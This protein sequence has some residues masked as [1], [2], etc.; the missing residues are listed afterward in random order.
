MR[1]GDKKPIYLFIYAILVVSFKVMYLQTQKIWMKDS[2][3][4]SK[5]E[6][7]TAAADFLIHFNWV[8]LFTEEELKQGQQPS[9][10]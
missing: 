4:G 2:Y 10:R 7:L 6:C 1:Y 9:V 8:L 5:P 3:P